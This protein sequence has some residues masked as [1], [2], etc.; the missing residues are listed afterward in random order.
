[1]VEAA[2]ALRSSALLRQT[3]AVVTPFEREGQLIVEASVPPTSVDAPAVVRAIILAVRP[4]SIADREAE[5]V[6]LTD[7]EL[8]GWRREA[9][10]IR[11]A[12]RQTDPID[13]LDSDARWFWAF[14][15]A[16]LGLETWL[17][18]RPAASGSQQVRDA[19]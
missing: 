7:A 18:Q 16:L 11:P 10:P 3:H 13:S 9:S 4:G 14:A 8:A 12:P 1:M 15:L 5:V 2:L 17:R 19:A 6:A